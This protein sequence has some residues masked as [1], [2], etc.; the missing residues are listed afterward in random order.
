MR[1]TIIV[2]EEVIEEEA[3]VVVKEEKKESKDPWYIRFSKLFF[4]YVW[5]PLAL[6][7]FYGSGYLL[8]Q[9]LWKYTYA[10]LKLKLEA[11]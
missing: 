7:I 6:G 1:S 10:Q 4:T 5:N 8:G 2:S 3:T 11:K 9:V